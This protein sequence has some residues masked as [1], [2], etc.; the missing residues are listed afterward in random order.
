MCRWR[1]SIAPKQ[2]LVPPESASGAPR[3]PPGASV[4]GAHKERHLLLGLAI[5]TGAPERRFLHSP[6]CCFPST[7]QQQAPLDYV[8]PNEIGCASSTR[9]ALCARHTHTLT[10]H[11]ASGR[12]SLQAARTHSARLK[13]SHFEAPTESGR[14]PAGRGA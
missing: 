7:W 2:Q 3:G 9:L 4:E 11:Q 5:K 10:S 8:A 14:G 13:A 6:S 12:H 1:K